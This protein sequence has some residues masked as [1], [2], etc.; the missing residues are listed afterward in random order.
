MRTNDPWTHR[1]MAEAAAEEEEGARVA[2]TGEAFWWNA[3]A[4]LTC[5]GLAA[6]AAGLTL[7]M[8]GLDPLMLLIKERA[9][10]SPVERGQAKRLLPMV[11]QHHRLLVTLLLMNSI[12]NEALPIF[13][14]ALV[15]P[16]VAILLSVTLV[17]FFGEI[18][19]SAV[20]TGPNQL[21]IASRLVPLVQAAMCLLYPL[22]GPIAKLLDWL[23]HD[24]DDE[25]EYTRGE[26]RALVRIQYEERLATKHKRKQ[27]RKHAVALTGGDHVGA[28]DFT[29]KKELRAAKSQLA[30]S[31][32]RRASKQNDMDEELVILAGTGEEYFRKHSTG[33]VL[34]QSIHGDEVMMVEGALQ[35]KTKVA[36]DVF[37]PMRKVFSIPSDMI[38]TERNMVKIYASGFTR[39]PVHAPGNKNDIIGVLM[40]KSLIVVG[41]KD[42]RPVNT[43]PL[44]IPYCV[45]P[46]MPLVDLLNLFQA[47]LRG[48]RGGHLALV[49]ARP[50]SAEKALSQ[51]QCLPETAGL[52]GIITLEDVLE[53]LLQEQI[54]DE[55]DKQEREAERLARM[56]VKHWQRYVRRKKEGRPMVV[57]DNG[58]QPALIPVVQRAVAHQV[59][60][61]TTGLLKP[62]AGT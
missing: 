1:I 61:E 41:P 52:M 9:A 28:L 58:I 3:A 47:P 44:R 54:Y 20:F 45:S 10:A 4:A 14:E 8:L 2:A 31:N 23:L 27:E 21:K 34:S 39:I 46:A 12:A 49:C 37:T 35:M 18:I 42:K 17:L 24:D 19:P 33:D 22:A 13:L 53:M 60:S 38:L 11:R 5:V 32:H 26:L 7:G 43:L 16:S 30:H 55:M 57:G 29:N 6:L 50:S 25:S 62:S 48:S 40:T 15:P 51:G 36:M 56:T 59:A